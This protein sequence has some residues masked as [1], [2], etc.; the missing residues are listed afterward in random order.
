MTSQVQISLN[1][2]LCLLYCSVCTCGFGLWV[3]GYGYTCGFGYLGV[4]FHRFV[5]LHTITCTCQPIP[6]N[7]WVSPYLWLTLVII[8]NKNLDVRPGNV[9]WSR[10]QLAR[11]ASQCLS[12][13]LAR[14]WSP[15]PFRFEIKS[16]S[17]SAQIGIPGVSGIERILECI[18]DIFSGEARQTFMQD[19]LDG[20]L[21]LW[22]CPWH[23]IPGSQF[24]MWNLL[25]LVVEEFVFCRVSSL[26]KGFFYSFIS[27]ICIVG[28]LNRPLD[29]QL[30]KSN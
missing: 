17:K 25:D 24:G 1:C 3:Y 23:E 11:T 20:I 12:D 18:P 2:L 4:G 26:V 5:N 16:R 14:E 15:V 8:K 7:L 27:A 9:I 22:C 30:S 13:L 29:I 21:L 19:S 6:E 28:Y 10:C